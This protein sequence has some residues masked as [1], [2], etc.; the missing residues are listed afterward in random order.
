[1]TIIERIGTKS[2]IALR[3][4]NAY[5]LIDRE[6]KELEWY[7]SPSEAHDALLERIDLVDAFQ[8]YEAR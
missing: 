3:G 6:T 1:M 2:I 5:A 8:T 4:T 7:T